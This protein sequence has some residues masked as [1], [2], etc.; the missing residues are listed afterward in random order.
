M[1]DVEDQ[2]WIPPSPL[3]HPTIREIQPKS[4]TKASNQSYLYLHSKDRISKSLMDYVGRL[5]VELWREIFLLE[6]PFINSE[7]LKLS[8]MITW[9]GRLKTQERRYLMLSI[10]RSFY[11][12]VKQL[13][14]TE[15][16]I[17]GNMRLSKFVHAVNDRRNQRN[18][19]AEHIKRMFLW[20]LSV[21]YIGSKFQIH[22]ADT[23]T[24]QL[25]KFSIFDTSPNL[26]YLNLSDVR[27]PQHSLGFPTS[28]SPVASNLQTLHFNSRIFDTGILSLLTIYASNLKHLY[29]SMSMDDTQDQA[30]QPNLP[31]LR[32]LNL[33]LLHPAAVVPRIQCPSLRHLVLA[34]R[35]SNQIVAA[36]QQYGS[37]ITELEIMKHSGD[38]WLELLPLPINLFDVCSHLKKFTFTVNKID[39]PP[40]LI[41]TR[42]TNLEALTLL[43]TSPQWS[44]EIEKLLQFFSTRRFINLTYV[45]VYVPGPCTEE[46]LRP[47]RSVLS[48]AFPEIDPVVRIGPYTGSDL[49]D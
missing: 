41:I 24:S 28:F 4:L 39:I 19:G 29:I 21:E 16:L 18:N 20:G 3:A 36:I 2:P 47:L 32:L 25:T 12:L 35:H 17:C 27:W 33:G 23:F 9:P 42:N 31:S 1:G 38:S 6:S 11:P 43:M 15:V 37:T 40:D 30:E 7:D 10:C 49:S 45:A 48:N 46:E 14:Y 8:D 34:V 22:F 26:N 44:P 5:P 13:L